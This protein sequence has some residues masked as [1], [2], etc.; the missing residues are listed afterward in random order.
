M[1]KF[2]STIYLS[3]LCMVTWAQ[4]PDPKYIPSDYQ[5]TTDEQ[6]SDTT[7]ST[8]VEKQKSRMTLKPLIHIGFGNFNFRG[9]ISDTRNTGIIGQSGFQIG[10]SSKITNNI[11]ATIMMEE[12]IVRVD[13]LNRND[14]PIN[15]MSTIN[16]IGFRFDYSLKKPESKAVFFPYVGVGLNYLKFD[17]KGSNDSSSD[18]Y[19]IDLLNEWLLDPENTEAY[20]KEGIDIPLSIGLKLILNERLN[21]NLSSTFHYTNTDYIDNVVDGASDNYFVN[22]A[23]LVYDLFCNDCKEEYVSEVKDNYIVNFESLDREDEDGD[24]VPDVDDFCIGTPSRVKVD[25]VGCPLD[26]DKDDVPDYLDQEAN[27]PLGAVVSSKGIQLT[28]KMSEAM[29]LNYLNA[30]SRKDATSYFAETYP[31]EKYIKITKE[32]VNIQGD[33]LL[34]DI[35]KPKIFNKIVQQQQQFEDSYTEAKYIDLNAQKIYKLQIAKHSAGMD[36]AE[37]N[38]LMSINNIKSTIEGNYTVYYSGEYD[39][40]L[41]A[42]QRQMQLINSGYNNVMIIEDIQGDLRTVTNDEIARERNKRASAKLDALPPLVDIVFRVQLDVLKEVDLDFYDLDDLVIF[43]DN[44]GFKHVFTDGFSSYE[45]ALERRNELY[46]MSYENAKVV[47]IKEGQIV[48]AEDYMDLDYNEDNA[49]VYGDIIFKVQIGVYSKNDVVE[50]AKVN[51]ID[52]VE[53]TEVSEGIFRYT[54]GTFTNIQAAMLRLNKLTSLGFEGCY[55]IAFYND[56]EISIKKAQEL[57]GY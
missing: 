27:T 29:Y 28:D 32:V 56:E 21:L 26:T 45:D 22:S 10:L 40:L 12:G 55:P 19:E 9:D 41:K 52:G 36:A 34:V 7:I 35:Y 17:S 3:L 13:G 42:N 50:I 11:N 38:R 14:L 4:I 37:I 54:S 48:K 24:G 2:L 53:K 8:G 20:S 15:F 25:A 39:D 5:N 44:E 43:K 16:T 23:H 18:E 49:A 47:A 1:K 30:T 46:Y 57:L 33:T 51:E 6:L 31:A